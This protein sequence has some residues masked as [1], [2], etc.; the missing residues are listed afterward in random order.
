MKKINYVDNDG[1][2]LKKVA[3]YFEI[4]EI[5]QS[6]ETMLLLPK[7]MADEEIA[8]M[9]E[10]Y[11]MEAD[12]LKEMIGEYEMTQMKKDMAVQQ[13]VTLVADA[14]KEA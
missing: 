4:N 10:M 1:N 9:A 5:G 7:N 6:I 14:A 8:K 11:K 13:A 2:E 12:K 3:I